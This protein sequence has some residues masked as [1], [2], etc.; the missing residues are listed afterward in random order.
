MVKNGNFLFLKWPKMVTNGPKWSYRD[1]NIICRPFGT[2]CDLLYP[3]LTIF[4]HFCSEK[5]NRF[6]HPVIEGQKWPFFKK[7]PKMSKMV[8]TGRKRCQLGCK[9]IH[10]HVGPFRA[11]FDHFWPFK[12][13]KKWPFM[14]TFSEKWSKIVIFLIFKI[15]KNGLKGSQMV[16][17]GQKY[18]LQ[19]IWYR[20][21]PFLTILGHLIFF[22]KMTIFLHFF[23]FSNAHISLTSKARDLKPLA[24]EPHWWKA[25]NETIKS[26]RGSRGNAPGWAGPMPQ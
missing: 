17:H 23:W 2:V 20:L 12:K 6:V 21:R 24:S 13:T 26:I 16:L 9:N 15:V 4:D 3:F 8:K 14:T 7:R 5:Y 1:T 11:V 18:Y 22:W 25:F 10:D 19:P